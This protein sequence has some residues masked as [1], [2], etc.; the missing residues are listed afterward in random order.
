MCTLYVSS[1]SQI[2]HSYKCRN[3]SEMCVC[4]AGD[5]ICGLES[6]KVSL[7]VFFYLKKRL[8]A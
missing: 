8:F 6:G 4:G 5:I 1:D 7:N 2:S 3:G